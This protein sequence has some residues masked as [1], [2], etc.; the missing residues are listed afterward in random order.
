MFIQIYIDHVK[1]QK[2]FEALIITK[3]EERFLLEH[4]RE[5]EGD[6]RD[7]I[8]KYDGVG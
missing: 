6:E 5:N 2:I 8:Q 7:Y 1:Q 3:M 4:E